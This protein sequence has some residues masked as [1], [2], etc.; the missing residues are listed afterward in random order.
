MTTAVLPVEIVAFKVAVNGILVFFGYVE[1]E[2]AL[3]GCSD[4][5]GFVSRLLLLGWRRLFLWLFR[6]F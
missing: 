4:S 2:V 3:F 5:C 1:N 6:R